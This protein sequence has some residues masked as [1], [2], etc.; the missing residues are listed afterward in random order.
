MKTIIIS[1]KHTTICKP[2]AGFIESQILRFK[3]SKNKV[4]VLTVI[5]TLMV[6]VK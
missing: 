2:K 1:K 6:F 5:A 4:F 3:A